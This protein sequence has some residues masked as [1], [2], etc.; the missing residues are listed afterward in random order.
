[1]KVVFPGRELTICEY[2][3]HMFGNS[4]LSLYRYVD[5]AQDNLLIDAMSAKDDSDRWLLLTFTTSSARAVQKTPWI[6]LGG[7]HSTDNR[8]W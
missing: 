6:I 5:E 3:R 1:M 8:C 2:C 4:S 7:R